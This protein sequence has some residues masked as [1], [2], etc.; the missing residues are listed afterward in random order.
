MGI[1]RKIAITG[2]KKVA[3]MAGDVLGRKAKYQALRTASK[4]INPINKA[5]AAVG[6][7]VL[8]AVRAGNQLEEEASGYVGK[9]VRNASASALNAMRGSR[10]M[11]RETMGQINLRKG[12]VNKK[13]TPSQ[14][15]SHVTD[16]NNMDEAMNIWKNQGMGKIGNKPN[17]LGENFKKIRRDRGT[18]NYNQKKDGMVGN[19]G[20]EMNKPQYMQETSYDQPQDNI[21]RMAKTYDSAMEDMKS[22]PTFRDASPRYT[23]KQVRAGRRTIAAAGGLVAASEYFKAKRASR[24]E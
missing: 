24:G 6:E 14:L 1:I 20:S 10:T 3:Q 23:D 18:M 4:V 2:A 5:G 19:A 15:D 17:D 8:N 7:G 9:Q 12:I 21:G 13:Y 16:K 22:T 11:P